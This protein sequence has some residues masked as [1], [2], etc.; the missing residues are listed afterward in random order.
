MKQYEF[1][2]ADDIVEVESGGYYLASDVNQLLREQAERIEELESVVKDWK[3]Y[4]TE[5]G[6]VTDAME[7]CVRAAKAHIS[8][9]ANLLVG[10][11]RTEAEVAFIEASAKL[12]AIRGEAK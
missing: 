8:A 1:H 4:N 11:E 6:E 7:E 2:Y 12:D 9:E 3:C 10:A 5:Q